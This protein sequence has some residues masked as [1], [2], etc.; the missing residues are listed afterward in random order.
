M[1]PRQDISGSGIMDILRLPMSNPLCC[2]VG[3]APCLLFF[4]YISKSQAHS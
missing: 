2:V 3:I 4:E 1:M